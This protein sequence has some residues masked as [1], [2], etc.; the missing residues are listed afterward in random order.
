MGAQTEEEGEATMG[1]RKAG[2]NNTVSN[3][4]LPGPC[5]SYFINKRIET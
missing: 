5:F 3:V 2:M 1:K 4:I